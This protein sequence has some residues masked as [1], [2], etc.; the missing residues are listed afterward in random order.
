MYFV[1]VWWRKVQKDFYIQNQ[2]DVSDSQSA[3]CEA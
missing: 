1:S 3:D 2:D